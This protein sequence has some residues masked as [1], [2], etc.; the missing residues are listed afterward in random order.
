MR[1]EIPEKLLG[2]FKCLERYGHALKEKHKEGFKRHIKMDDANMCLYMDA[3]IPR[4]KEWVKVDMDLARE[5]GARRAKK[6]SEI[7]EKKLLYTVESDDE[8]D[9]K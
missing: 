7:A 2:D 3:F 9:D 1:M 8:K 4:V 6:R 5:D